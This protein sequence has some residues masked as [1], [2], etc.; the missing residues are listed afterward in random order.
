MSAAIIHNGNFAYKAEAAP[1]PVT[2]E[3]SVPHYHG[4]KPFLATKKYTSGKIAGKQIWLL[5]CRI[6]FICNMRP[7]SKPND[8]IKWI[9]MDGPIHFVY[10]RGA[11][12][13][14]WADAD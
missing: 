13:F 10:L 2:S 11:I 5:C 14:P 12:C 6:L 9:P 8:S 3:S 7:F 1:G 4:A